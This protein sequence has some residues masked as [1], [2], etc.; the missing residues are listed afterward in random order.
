M[1][2]LG[3]RYCFLVILIAWNSLEKV[4]KITLNSCN[5]LIDFICM[6]CTA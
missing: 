2:F 3:V 1:G 4:Q 6:Y 5:Y